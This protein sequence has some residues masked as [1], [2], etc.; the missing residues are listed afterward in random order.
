MARSA[1]Q[2]TGMVYLFPWIA[3][4]LAFQL[5]PM[6]AS[7]VYS[8]TDFRL[9]H[10]VT[11]IGLMNYTQLLTDPDVW[12]AIG[13][14]LLFTAITVPLKLIVAMCVALL[15]NRPLRGLTVYRTLYY[16]PSILG[17]SVAAAVLWTALFRDGGVIHAFCDAIGLPGYSWLTSPNGALWTIILFRVWEFGSPMLLFLAALQQIPQDTI[18]AARIDGA[19]GIPLFFRIRL[20]M[21]G[22]VVLYHGMLQ[23]CAALQEFNAPYI[24][25]NGGPRGATTFLSLLLYRYAFSSY[26]MGLASAL[27]WILFL[28]SATLSVAFLLVRRWKT[29]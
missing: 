2:K 12:R 1:K 19:N 13:R 3:G 16:L 14:T 7:L 8:L 26:E 25:T 20:P 15:L 22:S 9:F 18:D 11:E 29:D 4:F 10:G 23:T 17:G 21:M 24:I 5:L 28:L 27:A 6:L